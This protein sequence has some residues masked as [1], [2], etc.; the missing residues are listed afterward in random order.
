MAT[1][2]PANVRRTSAVRQVIAAHPVGAMLL[3]M[4]V[5][6]GVLLVPPALAGLP[7]EPFLLGV[8]LFGQLGP[9]LLVT[10]AAGGRP[11][12]RELFRRVFRWRVHPGWYVLALLG[13]PL[14][15]LLT[16][17]AVFGPGAL[18]A[19][20]TDPSVIL[21]YLG[22][23]AILPLVNLWEETAWMGVVQARLARRHGML[24]AAVI[25]GPLFGLVHLPLH[26]GKPLGG[27]LLGTLVLMVLAIPLRLVFGWLYVRTGASILIVA[28]MHAT[29]NA[30]SNNTL[31]TA[32]AP[33]NEVLALTPAAVVVVWALLIVAL[34]R[35]AAAAR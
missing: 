10:G 6:A 30:T 32:A 11:A 15:A 26:L 21:V 5:V 8:V 3:M 14:A 25:T 19:L 29:Y 22:Q 20:V 18:F 31:L 27:V 12:V 23:L 4:F 33:G 9:A 16:S 7:Q 34:D 35:R 1:T 17:A 13:L 24:I 28:I 2:G